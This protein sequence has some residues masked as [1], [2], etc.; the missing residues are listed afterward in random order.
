MGKPSIKAQD[1]RNPSS[2]AGDL[3]NVRGR[4]PR[5]AVGAAVAA[6]FLLV[7]DAREA[8]GQ[9]G[10]TTQIV[11]EAM[12]FCYRHVVSGSGSS[13]NAVMES[14]LTVTLASEG[15]SRTCTIAALDASGQDVTLTWGEGRE[16][17]RNWIDALGEPLPAGDGGMFALTTCPAPGTAI[18][19]GVGTYPVL[20]SIE[21][22]ADVPLQARPFFA[23]F[24]RSKRPC[25]ADATR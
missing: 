15:R 18:H 10:E 20:Q 9:D 13:P 7:F 3:N 2:A 19:V 6:G 14:P 23:F 4:I 8:R 17:A 21:P 22:F 11:R 25:S 5:P 16:A 1:D 12:D 24:Q